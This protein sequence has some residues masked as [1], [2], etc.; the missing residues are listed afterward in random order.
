MPFDGANSQILSPVTHMLIEGRDRVQ[1]GWSQRAMRRRGSVCMIGS[2]TVTDYEV[3]AIAEKLM[4]QAIHELGYAHSSVVAFN[5]DLR[6][7]KGQV[8]EV[9]DMAIALSMPSTRTQ[10]HWQY[11]ELIAA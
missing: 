6:R 10:H 2:L 7:T 9:Y 3:F 4:L 8:L 1:N 11:H 5:D